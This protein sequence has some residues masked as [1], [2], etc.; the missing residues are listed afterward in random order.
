LKNGTAKLQKK[1]ETT[2]FFLQKSQLFLQLF[3]KTLITAII[4]MGIFFSNL[5]GS[6]LAYEIVHEQA[7]YVI[8]QESNLASF[9]QAEQ[10]LYQGKD[11][12]LEQL[13]H[14]KQRQQY[15]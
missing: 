6:S 7:C 3:L 8:F 5:S 14:L 15:Q 10:P 11:E 1:N 12:R 9:P 13:Q 4:G 2:K